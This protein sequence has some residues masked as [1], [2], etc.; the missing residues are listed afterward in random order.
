MIVDRLPLVFRTEGP[1][2]SV[3]A[4]GFGG[5]FGFVLASACEGLQYGDGDR[6][7]VDA[8]VPAQGRAGVGVAETVGAEGHPVARNPPRNEVRYGAHP[9]AD[10]DD[11]TGRFSQL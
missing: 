9:V 2:H 7:S 10:R 4:G 5:C 3:L 6:R 11:R 8:E 1:L